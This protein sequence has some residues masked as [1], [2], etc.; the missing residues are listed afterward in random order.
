MGQ[1][2]GASLTA[3]HEMSDKIGLIQPATGGY[4]TGIPCLTDWGQNSTYIVWLAVA[5][6]PEEGWWLT[7][8]ARHENRNAATCRA[9]LIARQADRQT[10][11]S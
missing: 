6:A 7:G 8:S 9:V 4:A 3:D 10:L 5:A 11:G 1:G 2:G